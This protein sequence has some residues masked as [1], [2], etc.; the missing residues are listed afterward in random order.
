MLVSPTSPYKSIETAINTVVRASTDFA[1]QS[2]IFISE[3]RPVDRIIGNLM[4][5]KFKPSK[6]KRYIRAGYPI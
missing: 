3:I 2:L 5:V 4:Q 6:L 1:Q